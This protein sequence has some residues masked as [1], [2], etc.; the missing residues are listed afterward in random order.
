MELNHLVIYIKKIFNNLNDKKILILEPKKK[1]NFVFNILLKIIIFY[2]LF[3]FK[4][5][6]SYL[7]KNII[8]ID[9]K[10]NPFS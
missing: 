5:V 2:L 4:K 7:P 8:E 3:S 9:N 6:E 10:I 1:F